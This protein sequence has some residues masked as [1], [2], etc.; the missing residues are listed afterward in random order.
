[1]AITVLVF[2]VIIIPIA[3]GYLLFISQGHNTSKNIK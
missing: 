3:L 2:V 1:V